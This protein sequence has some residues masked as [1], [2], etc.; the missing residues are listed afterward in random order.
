MRAWR[1]MSG[2]A[3]VMLGMA[4]LPSMACAQAQ[5]APAAA[6]D[7]NQDIVVTAQKREQSLQDVP[8]SITA[9]NGATLDRQP[10][11]GLTQAL[12]AV[13][14]VVATPYFQS[15]GTSITVRGVSAAGP[16]F[17][18]S[19]P[20]SYYLDTV[21]F[22]FVK[23]AF[24]PDANAY[25]LQRVEI[26]RGPQGTLY[27]ASALNGVVRVLTHDADLGDLSFKARGSIAGTHDGDPVYRAD[28]ALNV[29]IVTDRLAVR[30]TGGAEDAGGWIDRVGRND[31]NDGQLY[32]L[33]FKIG[34]APVDGLRIDA[35]AWLSRSSF[36]APSISDDERRRNTA[37]AEPV[38]NDY[39][40]FGLKI[41]YDVAG[42][43]LTSSTGYLNY[44]NPG[45]LDYA[46]YGLA[47]TLES[48]FY[49][50]IFSQEVTLSSKATSRLQWTIGGSY[51][52]ARDLLFQELPAI[53]QVKTQDKS[54]AFAAFGEV[55]F[56]ATPTIDVTGGLRYFHDKVSNKNVFLAGEPDRATFEAVTPR[57]VAAWHPSRQATV[58]ASY[59]QGFRSGAL[60]SQGGVPPGFPTLKPDRL[61]NYEIGAKGS[62]LDGTLTY[63]AAA[64]YIYWKDVQQSLT[65]PFNQVVITALVN[66][67]SASGAG[68]DVRVGARPLPGLNVGLNANWN[69]LRV[70]ADVISA[71][72]VLFAKG[73]RLNLSPEWT[74]GGSVNYQVPLDD[75]NAIEAALSGNYTSAQA[76]RTIVG[77]AA[78]IAAGR[79]QFV[80]RASVAFHV[81]K[82]YTA[83]LFVDNLTDEDRGIYGNPFIAANYRDQYA[84][85]RPRTIGL[86]LEAGF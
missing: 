34:A 76:L 65:V 48:D 60:Q 55:T 79:A 6:D 4:A 58:Y 74:V 11:G 31:V 77:N 51:R 37:V 73:D 43:V 45:I 82:D 86:Q 10:S 46:E 14:G 47:T 59:S 44:R 72:A 64:Y 1:W 30:I 71:G 62:A 78:S 42:A 39:D 13:P 32:N 18:G 67:K 69:D 57:A 41:A 25:D 8:I 2:A 38:K 22:G 26:L 3:G 29:P 75:G 85:V 9:I 16:V 20:V 54:D 68:V 63:E 23:S 49:S 24:A 80:S 7:T 36:G 61:H 19:S 66:G 33:R 70:G 15:N 27:G 81:R 53:V 12:N 83:T 35:S 5:P 40:A 56:A 52:N 50:K 28:A 21:P 17:N 84:H